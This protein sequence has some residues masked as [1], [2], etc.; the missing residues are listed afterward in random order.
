M[1]DRVEKMTISQN[2]VKNRAI[3]TWKIRHKNSK[4]YAKYDKKEKVKFMK[5]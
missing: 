5:Y 1:R 3:K 2:S 4:T